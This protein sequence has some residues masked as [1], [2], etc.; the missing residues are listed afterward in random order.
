MA[1]A[2]L[3]PW[4]KPRVAAV[5]LFASR[6]RIEDFLD[7]EVDVTQVKARRGIAGLVRGLEGQT[8]NLDQLTPEQRPTVGRTHRRTGAAATTTTAATR[9]RC[10]WSRRIDHPLGRLE[11]R[12][13]QPTAIHVDFGVRRRQLGPHAT[14]HV[15]KEF[16][17]LVGA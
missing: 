2:G 10:R 7:L 17:E 14:A 5:M 13:L 12:A 6:S 3:P 11:V 9:R 15:A 8:L 16:G 1:G 4:A